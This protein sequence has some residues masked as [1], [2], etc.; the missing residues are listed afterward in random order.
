M[1][2]ENVEIVRE[3]FESFRTRD[4]ERAF[5]Y[6]D[7]DIEWDSTRALFAP[8]EITG[9]YHGHDA[10]RKYW[11]RW[12]EAWEDLEFSVSEYI[13]AGDDVVALLDAQEQWGKHSGIRTEIPPYGLVFTFK[14]GKVIRWRAFGDQAEALHAAGIEEQAS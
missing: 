2:K 9:V 11:R 3:L 7:P 10:I 8:P 5:D 1:S 13:D 4:H 6:Y 12:L 14:D